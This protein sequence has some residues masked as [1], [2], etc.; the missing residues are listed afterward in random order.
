M[1]S[2]VKILRNLSNNFTPKSFKNYFSQVYRHK[3]GQICT[4]SE[5]WGPVDIC[6]VLS[7]SGHDSELVFSGIRYRECA[8]RKLRK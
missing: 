3:F 4:Y 8:F 2:Y 5:S 7:E 6:E 1:T